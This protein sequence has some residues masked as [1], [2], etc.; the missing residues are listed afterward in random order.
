VGIWRFPLD[1]AAGTEG[2]EVAAI[3]SDCLPRDDVEGLAILDGPV[4]Y[5]VASAQ[6]IHRAALFAST[7][8][9]CRPARR[10]WRSRPAPSTA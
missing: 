9:R 6:G 3:P 7:A 10:W 8:R 1:P 5:L 2:T 4:R